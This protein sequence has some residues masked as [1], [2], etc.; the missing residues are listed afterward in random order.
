MVYLFYAAILFS[1]L[2]STVVDS[3]NL[4]HAKTATIPAEFSELVS[5]KDFEKSQS[6]LGAQTLFSLIRRSLMTLILLLTIALG[7]FGILNE[8][9][10]PVSNEP[11]LQALLF[12]ASLAMISEMLSLPFSYFHTF[13]LEERFGF[14]RSTLATFCFDRIKGWILTVV[15]GAPIGWALLWFFQNGGT[16]AWAWSWLALVLFQLVLMFLAPVL[17]MPIFYKFTPL[18]DGD[19]KNSIEGYAAKENF[20]IQ[21]VF[22]MDGSKRS[23]KANAFFTGFGPFRRIVLFDTLIAKHSTSELLAVLAHEV[24]HYKLKHIQKQM[25]LSFAVS[26]LLFFALG[27]IMQSPTLALALGFKQWSLQG[28]ILAA[29]FL[30]GPLSILLDIFS[31]AISRKFEFEADAFAVRTTGSALPLIDALKK[32][33]KE[34]LSNLTPHPWK[35]ILEYSHPPMVDRLK[36]LRGL[37][38][39]AK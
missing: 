12:F 23:S 6:Y 27:N 11:V 17:L 36:A 30:Y 2:L 4:N 35:V 8:V 24:G 21:G 38:Q 33:S 16:F 9:L 7:G 5:Q 39:H 34:N 32:L 26:F 25:L 14:N 37:V 19:L 18:S 1:D 22:T 31:S 28:G 29:A 13:G 20:K 15:I 10:M 3:L